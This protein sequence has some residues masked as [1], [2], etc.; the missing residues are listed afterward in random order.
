MVEN[1]AF[2]AQKMAEQSTPKFAEKQPFKGN[3]STLKCSYC[4]SI[5]HQM[6]RC[7]VLHPELKPKNLGNRQQ[8]PKENPKKFPRPRANVASHEPNYSS[9]MN[10]LNE[11]ASFL[12]EKQNFG[13]NG[14]EGSS[15]ENGVA[16]A[17]LSNFGLTR[18]S[19]GLTHE[20]AGLTRDFAEKFQGM[21]I[22][23][24]TAL[25]LSNFHNIWVVDS[26][27]S[28]HM[29]NKLNKI[30]DFIPFPKSSFVSIANGSTAA[31]K[32]KGKIK[33]VSK[34]INSDILYVPSFPFQLLSV[35]R[36]TTSLNCDV[37]FTPFK[38]LFQDHYTKQKIGEGFH[39]N[40]LYFSVIPKF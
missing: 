21:Y 1:R 29:T 36:L 6:D 34:I 24:M 20:S 14:E 23:L 2:V 12:Q 8:F 37:I 13:R 25:E 5:G 18:E 15:A 4:N 40:G 30:H 27:A 10:L 7:W 22:A 19:A 38:V 32:G 26:G 35:H 9:P 16:S 28:D 39:L 3:R 31:V 17:F 33:I 11:F